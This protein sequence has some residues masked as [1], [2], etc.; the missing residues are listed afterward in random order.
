MSKRQIASAFQERL[1]TLIDRRGE[2]GAAFARRCNLDRSALSQFLDAGNPR[3]PR[4]ETLTSIATAEGISVDWL[5]GLTEDEG[6]FGEVA[7]QMGVES[8]GGI[9]GNSPLSK[10][11]REAA[12]FKIR[13]APANLP[14]LFRTQAVTDYEFAAGPHELAEAK[15]DQTIQQLDY[16]RMSETDME[17]VLPKQRLEAFAKGQGVWS[18]LPASTRLEQLDRIIHLVGELYPTF[19]MFLYDELEHYCAPYTV[20]G[21][22]RAVVYLGGMY[23]VIHSSEHIRELTS[24]F[25]RI[26]KVSEIAPDRCVGWLKKL[27]KQ[28]G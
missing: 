9:S 17:V 10:W 24:H 23:L 21:P 6:G 16:S 14:D 15:S 8:D 7:S 18:A 11:H 20:F 12:G 28:V 13:Y 22:K 25:D 4:A 27:A 1:K 5:L 3:L 2:T 19:R 26:I